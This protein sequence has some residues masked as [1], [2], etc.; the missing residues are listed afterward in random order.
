MVEDDHKKWYNAYKHCTMYLD[1]CQLIKNIFLEFLIDR[2]T[3]QL[4]LTLVQ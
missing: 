3:Q 1:F 2:G 4:L